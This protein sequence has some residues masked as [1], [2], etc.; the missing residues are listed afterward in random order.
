ML[1][2]L[3]L[4]QFRVEPGEGGVIHLV[5]DAPGRSMNVFSN[6][7]IA[8]LGRFTTWLRRSDIPGVVVR[9]GK[10][11][12]FCAGAD[13]TELGVAYD[14][15]VAA[16][17][18]QRGQVAYDHFFPLSQ[19][20]RALE[21]SGKP[22]AAALGGLA[23]GGGCELALACHY[24]VMADSPQVFLGLPESLVGL[25]PG[26][27]G[28]QRLPRLVGLEAALPVLL[29]GRRFGSAEALAVGAAHAVVAPGQEVRAA[30]H[31]VLSAGKTAQ[32]WD[33]VLWMDPDAEAL[34]AR[35]TDVLRAAPA[36]YP[37]PVAIV[38][39]IRQGL[40]LPMDEAIRA[41]M[42]VFSGLIQRPEPRNMIQ[43]LF[44][45]KQEYGR[46]AKSNTLPPALAD[47]RADVAG[48]LAE[49]ARRARADGLGDDDVAGALKLAGFTQ[50][51]SVWA[52]CPA[53]QPYT[54]PCVAGRESAGL[55]FEAPGEGVQVQLGR[56]LLGAVAEA[57]LPHLAQIAAAEQRV[58]DYALVSELG[59]PAYVGG[60]LALADYLG[61]R[62]FEMAR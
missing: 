57:A 29:E 30:E 23:L 16:P 35:L 50:P 32:P 7:A 49:V 36:H 42:R 12:G 22:V 38:D 48:A 44:L 1:E 25:L 60:P 61:G 3:A 39:C 10:A 54:R 47:V 52:D 56:A 45:G 14:M 51:L 31:W 46:L 5:F 8:E 11:A 41:E 6:A 15:I 28:T 58:I 9:S 20:L 40:P 59:I 4:E 17:R 19:A 18:E 34:D 37:A 2:N 13:L 21:T 62:M 27:G 53:P 24:R 43:T 26:A 33:D 55:W